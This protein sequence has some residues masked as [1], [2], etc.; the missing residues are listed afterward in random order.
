MKDKRKLIWKEI[1]KQKKMK[2][3]VKEKAKK[4]L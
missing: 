1:K 3:N 4:N 2:E